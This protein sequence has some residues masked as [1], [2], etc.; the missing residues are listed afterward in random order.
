M[1]A[2]KE[3]KCPYRLTVRIV[4]SQPTDEISI[5]SRATKDTNSNKKLDIIRKTIGSNP[6]AIT[7]L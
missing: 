2:K 6:I 4:G 3:I 1:P 5:I 7:G